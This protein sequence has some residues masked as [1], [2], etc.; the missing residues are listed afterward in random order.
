MSLLTGVRRM[1]SHEQICDNSDVFWKSQK[2][3]HTH[4]L[5][6]SDRFRFVKRT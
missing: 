3:T 6:L 5:R 4:A 2:L 1:R